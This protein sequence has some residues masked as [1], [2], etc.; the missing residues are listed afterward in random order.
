MFNLNFSIETEGHFASLFACRSTGGQIAF[1]AE[2]KKRTGLT[3]MAVGMIARPDQ[4]DGIV[5]SGDA[6]FVAVAR[7]FLDDPRWGI[8]AAAALGVDIRYA[9]QYISAR[10]N[11]WL[12]FS[13]AHPDTKPPA[14]KQQL[15][16]PPS[17][18]WDR[19]PEQGETGAC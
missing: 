13:Y 8:H 11:N 6:D 7:M 12:G 17:V 16:R 4:A 19:P 3:A 9:S 18:A 15:D 2:I 1:A 14:S 5:A 10:P